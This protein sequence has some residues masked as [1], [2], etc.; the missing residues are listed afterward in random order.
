VLLGMAS[1]ATG[2]LVVAASGA[3]TNGGYASVGAVGAGTA[4][5]RTTP[6]G[7]P[8]APSMC[9]RHIG[10]RRHG[11]VA[12]Q[13]APGCQHTLRWQAAPTRRGRSIKR[14][15]SRAGIGGWR[16]ADWRQC[17]GR[18]EPGCHL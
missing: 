12:R 18:R 11:M 13:C 7:M 14:G 1:G 3:L 10:Q 17:F 6:F 2:V 4:T 8:Q 9:G 16:V 15:T 5:L